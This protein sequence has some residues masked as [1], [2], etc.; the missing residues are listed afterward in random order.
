MKKSVLVLTAIL[1]LAAGSANAQKVTGG[2]KA[3]A[4]MSN[5]IISDIGD[6]QSKMRVGGSLGGFMNV[7]FSDN[8]S[9]QPELLL[10][11]NFSEF[12]NAGVKGDFSHWGLELP[13]YFLGKVDAGAD[14]AYLGVGPYVGLGL[15][16][17]NKVGG[18]KYDLYDKAEAGNML[19]RRFD[20]G[21]GALLTYEFDFG[22]FI[23]GSYKIG[24]INALESDSRGKMFP[25]MVSVGVGYKF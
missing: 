13:V 25:Q 15:S 20:F 9:M 7:P 23:S 24:I 1:S 21:F 19:M 12:R 2:V 4:N 8:F 17:Q 22:M 5:F 3:N 10:N 6:L 18:T 14:K 16:A 11:M